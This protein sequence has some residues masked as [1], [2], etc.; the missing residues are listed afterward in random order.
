MNTQAPQ[1]P[2]AA[3]THQHPLEADALLLLAAV[4]AQAPLGCVTMS[5]M[6]VARVPAVMVVGA[7]ATYQDPAAGWFEDEDPAGPIAAP[8]SCV[9]AK[10]ASP[11]G[12]DGEYVLSVRGHRV[13]VYCKGMS[14]TPTEYL[15]L[16]RTGDGANTSHYGHG[17]NTAPEGLTT[18]YTKVRFHP[19]TLLVDVADTTFASSTGWNQF[20]KNR[21]DTWDW[22]NAGDCAAGHSET[23]TASIDLRGTPFAVGRGQFATTGYIPAGSVH[24]SADRQVVTLTG[25]GYCGQTASTTDQLQLTWLDT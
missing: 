6:E 9:E 20:G 1:P 19:D 18:S 4:L 8:S 22:G 17:P 5:G 2:S 25:G 11:G 24:Y 7:G 16:Q 21:H 12:V 10:A 3:K 23:G 15:T 13:S 14:G